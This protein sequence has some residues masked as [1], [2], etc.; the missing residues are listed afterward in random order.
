MAFGL[1]DAGTVGRIRSVWEIER[2]LRRGQDKSPRV[3]PSM[4]Y[5]QEQFDH[6]LR[7]RRPHAMDIDR[8]LH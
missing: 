1:S 3:V 8:I 6:A 2:C 7:E 5:T 4:C